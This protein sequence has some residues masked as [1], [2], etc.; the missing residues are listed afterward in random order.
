M[1]EDVT[2][3]GIDRHPTAISGTA[4]RWL[5]EQL[6]DP[7]FRSDASLEAAAT[8][9][10]GLGSDNAIALTA[11]SRGALSEVLVDAFGLSPP[12]LPEGSAEELRWL[13]QKIVESLKGYEAAA[14]QAPD[15]PSDEASETQ[16]L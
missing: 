12:P 13:Q 2:F 8:I 1:T 5:V 16:I 10:T 4:T 6:R 9:E 15:L 7:R 11:D 14:A 3:A